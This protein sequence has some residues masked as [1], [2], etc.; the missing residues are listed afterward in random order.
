MYHL[1]VRSKDI[2]FVVPSYNDS[3][4]LETTISPLITVG[5]VVVVD[6]GS[7]QIVELSNVIE[8]DVHVIRHVMNRG[9]GAAIETGLEYIRK[10][11]PDIKYIV[12]FDADGQHNFQ[13]AINMIGIARQGYEIVLGSRFLSKK[14]Q[15]PLIKEAI[16]RIFANTYSLI[17][18]KKITD[19][20][21]G[22]R[23]LSRNFV[24]QNQ[25][26]MS[27]FEH[28]DEILDLILKGG[29]KFC[30]FPC[31]VNYTEYS[32]SKGQPLIN[33]INIFFNKVLKKL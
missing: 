25:L 4:V 31:S 12:T 23:V 29:W 7:R 13:D 20:H 8:K 32:K 19:R 1:T 3:S 9:Q 11:M 10:Q 30:E 18:G 21:F 2:C 14:S 5:E 26:L 33:G 24:M 16:L 28:A 15:I 17:N 27:G 22:L 6:D